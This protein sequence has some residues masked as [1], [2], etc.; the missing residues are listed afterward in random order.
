MAA[1]RAEHMGA[2]RLEEESS[3]KHEPTRPFG[4]APLLSLPL[5]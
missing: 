2:E 3:L 1:D 4:R 5:K